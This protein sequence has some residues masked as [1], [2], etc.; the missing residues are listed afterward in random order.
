MCAL[1]E[2]QREESEHQSGNTNAQVITLLGGY[3]GGLESTYTMAGSLYFWLKSYLWE[4]LV[5]EYA[6]DLAQSSGS[7]LS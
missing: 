1:F 5:Y 6:I 3:V 4:S 7:L 2:C